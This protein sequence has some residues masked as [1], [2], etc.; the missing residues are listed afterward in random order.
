MTTLTD[1][2]HERADLTASPDVAIEGVA[3]QTAQQ[4]QRKGVSAEL[5]RDLLALLRR[6]IHIEAFEQRRTRLV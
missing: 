3:E 1:I 4:S 5:T 2:L 6:A